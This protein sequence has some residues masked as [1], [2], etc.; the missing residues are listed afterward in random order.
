V[1]KFPG[2]AA[3][4]GRSCQVANSKL[5]F[6]AIFYGR[7]PGCELDAP[8]APGFPDT[9]KRQTSAI[10]ISPGLLTDAWTGIILQDEAFKLPE[11][12]E[13]KFR[14]QEGGGCQSC[15]AGAAGVRK[16]NNGLLYDYIATETGIDSV[17]RLCPLPLTP[18]SE[19][20]TLANQG[21]WVLSWDAPGAPGVHHGDAV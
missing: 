19:L 12:L 9:E 6:S 20:Q 13:N 5:R 2:P 10:F 3:G 17:H 14:I 11:N 15:A 1:D 16:E 8:G 7:V 4:A 21:L 18:N